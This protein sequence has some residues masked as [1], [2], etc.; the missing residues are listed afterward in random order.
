MDKEPST[1]T[2][3]EPENNTCTRCKPFIS[4]VVVVVE[5]VVVVEEED[6]DEEEEVVD[7]TSSPN[8]SFICGTDSPV[9]LASLTT[10]APRNKTQSQGIVSL[11]VVMLEPPPPAE[12]PDASFP[13]S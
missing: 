8:A 13:S 12:P 6:D 3:E 7:G 11:R 4:K 5:G 1:V 10:A 2:K 9:K